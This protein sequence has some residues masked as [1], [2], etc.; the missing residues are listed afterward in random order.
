MNLI[1]LF[2]LFRFN[3]HIQGKQAMTKENALSAT[4]E[5]LND[6]LTESFDFG[7][8]EETL[9]NQLEE[10]LADLQFLKEEKDKIGSPENLG[11]VI[12]DVV[13]EQFLNQIATTAGEDF[14]KANNGL[15]LDLRNEA[16]I[17]TTENFAKGK[18][19]SHNTDLNCF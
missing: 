14:I 6:D 5:Q 4:A 16:H 15:H 12:M 10:E 17:Q 13:W 2:E 11:N 9:Q 8:L 7:E 3:N 1:I 18:I 19:A